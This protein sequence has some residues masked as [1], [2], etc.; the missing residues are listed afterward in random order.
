M[1]IFRFA[2]I[3]A[4]GTVMQA[5]PLSQPA[6]AADLPPSLKDTPYVVVPSWEGFYFGGHLG[7]AIGNTGVNDTFTYVG[8]PNLNGSLSNT[9]FIG[10]CAGWIQL[11]ARP[12]RVRCGRRYRLSECIGEAGRT[13]RSRLMYRSLQD[14]DCRTQGRYC[15]VNGKYSSSSDLYGDLTARLGYATDRTLFYVKG[16]VALLDADFKAHYVGQNCNNV[17]DCGGRWL[18]N[19]PSQFNFT[20]AARLWGGPSERVPNMH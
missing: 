10:R 5:A 14:G 7:G 19:A 3:L 11:P 6:A 20:T 4:A 16:G 8:D 17:W 2:L 1:R 13:A 18:S 9:G 12:L 15:K